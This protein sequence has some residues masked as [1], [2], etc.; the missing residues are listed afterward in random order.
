MASQDIRYGTRKEEGGGVLWCIITR[1]YAPQVPK[2]PGPRR[3]YQRIQ[4]ECS[5]IG[6]HRLVGAAK[7]CAGIPEIK[8]RINLRATVAIGDESMT[9]RSRSTV[10]LRRRHMVAADI[11]SP[12]PCDHSP[13][14]RH[15]RGLV[16]KPLRHQHGRRVFLTIPQCPTRCTRC[17]R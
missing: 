2:P 15:K 17:E 1:P 12:P 6:I 4:Q 14:S 8:K 3:T 13:Y 7:S 5:L 11:W 16:C 9:G 10:S